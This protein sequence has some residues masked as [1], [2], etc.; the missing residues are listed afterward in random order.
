[1][2]INNEMTEQDWED[3]KNSELKDVAEGISSYA[4]IFEHE[5]LGLH[6]FQVKITEDQ[7][8]IQPK[9]FEKQ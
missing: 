7:A 1:M 8:T 2:T 5:E 4:L 9:S 3:I 6:G